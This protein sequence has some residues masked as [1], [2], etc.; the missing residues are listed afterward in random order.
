MK[1]IPGIQP[2]LLK[3]RGADK[4]VKR[5]TDDLPREN[6]PRFLARSSRMRSAGELGEDLQKAPYV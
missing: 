3:D 5:L 4:E 1:W 6:K 2:L